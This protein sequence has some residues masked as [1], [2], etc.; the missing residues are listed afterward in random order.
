MKQKRCSLI[1]IGMIISFIFAGC[2]THPPEISKI[3]DATKSKQ[4]ISAPCNLIE[5]KPRPSWIDHPPH[6]MH[7]LYGVGI[8]PRQSPVSRQVQAARILAMRDI[9]Q[10]I[11]VHV[12]SLY[13]ENQT[14]YDSEIQSRIQ[15]K[16]EA[17]LRGVR[18]VDQWNDIE[19]CS[20][21][22]LASVALSH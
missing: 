6:S 22:M 8:A 2:V 18:Y 7:H 10:Q 20:I 17:L 5:T 14:Q 11:K 9:S 13:E 12:E 19:N 16:S 3:P 21:Y 1:L 15:E 4:K